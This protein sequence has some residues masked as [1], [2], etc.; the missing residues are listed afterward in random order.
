MEGIPKG[1]HS[2][3][4]LGCF[5]FS[6][7]FVQTKY[8]AKTRIRA[9]PFSYADPDVDKQHFPHDRFLYESSYFHA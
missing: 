2:C 9:F 3:N 1:F 8:G 6:S 4:H 7:T 5:F